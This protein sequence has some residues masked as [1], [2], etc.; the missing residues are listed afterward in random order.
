MTGVASH[1]RGRN[2]RVATPVLALPGPRFLR[3]PTSGPGPPSTTSPY[4]ARPL[5]SILA[6]GGPPPRL[7]GILLPS[8]SGGP[9]GRLWLLRDPLG[10]LSLVLTQGKGCVWQKQLYKYGYGE[11]S[12]AR[13]T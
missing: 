12:S 2:L 5:T 8:Q 7:L 10:A 13:V 11:R 9:E 4:L 1:V 6:S 3:G